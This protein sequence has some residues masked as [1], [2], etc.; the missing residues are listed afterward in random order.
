MKMFNPL[1]PERLLSVTFSKNDSG[2]CIG[3]TIL[4]T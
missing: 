3:R 2:V 1:L 4:K